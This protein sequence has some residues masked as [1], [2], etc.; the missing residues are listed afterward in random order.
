MINKYFCAV[1]VRFVNPYIC[2]HLTCCTLFCYRFDEV[3]E[4]CKSLCDNCLTLGA[5]SSVSSVALLAASPSLVSL[6]SEHH[7]PE[8][9]IEHRRPSDRYV[10]L[11]GEEEK[12]EEEE[13]E[14]SR[15]MLDVVEKAA[16]EAAIRSSRLNNVS[17]AIEAMRSRCIFCDR[18]TC[19]FS[20][21]SGPCSAFFLAM[22][23][24]EGLLHPFKEVAPTR[25]RG[26]AYCFICTYPLERHPERKCCRS[27]DSHVPQPPESRSRALLGAYNVCKPCAFC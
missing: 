5:A 6:D 2:R 23:G 9:K 10:L 22:W 14:Q 21:M 27:L 26:K 16:F 7:A 24:E 19:D 8:E 18:E 4:P 25:V 1:R 3:C 20:S 12:S 11:E 17:L 15:A 13:D